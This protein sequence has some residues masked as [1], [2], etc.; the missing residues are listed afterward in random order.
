MQLRQMPVVL[1]LVGMLADPLLGA[2]AQTDSGGSAAQTAAAQP[3][4]PAARAPGQI[5]LGFSFYEAYNSS[6]TGS[7][8]VQTPDN[9]PGGMFEM[10]YIR[11]PLVGFEF[12]YGLNLSTETFAP[13]ASNC[14]YVCST[15]P[16]KLQAKASIASLDWIFSRKIGALRPFAVAGLGFFIDSTDRSIY[17]VNTV[18]RP[19]YVV[20][21][22]L[23]WA[24]L[25]RAGLRLQYRDTVYRAPNLSSLFPATGQFTSTSEPMGGF[26]YVF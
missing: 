21:G 18:V 11:R 2:S 1:I 8:V 15:A 26:Y 12:A 6:S 22:G 20:G 5:D 17:E 14:G 9:S 13:S 24:F 23:D 19:A 3:Q 4:R 10:R 7:G 25:P 16:L